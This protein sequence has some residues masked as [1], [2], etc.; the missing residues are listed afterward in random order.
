MRQYESGVSTRLASRCWVV[1]DGD[2][3]AVGNADGV[4]PVHDRV[5]T[6]ARTLGPDAAHEE[7]GFTCGY[8]IRG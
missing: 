5:P 6:A 7:Y 4:A 3:D 8:G 1:G 2:R